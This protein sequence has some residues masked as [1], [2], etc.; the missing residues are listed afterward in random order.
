M[1]YCLP[2]A[3]QHN[4]TVGSLTFTINITYLNTPNT[5]I[6]LALRVWGYD[7]DLMFQQNLN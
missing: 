5:A 6:G 2:P 1:T 7:T 3:T 4:P